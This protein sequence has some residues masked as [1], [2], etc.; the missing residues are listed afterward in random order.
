MARPITKLIAEPLAEGI[1]GKASKAA[2]DTY[3]SVLR[4]DTS[5]QAEAMYNRLIGLAVKADELDNN[6][7][8]G[9]VE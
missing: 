1:H 8:E 5:D 2:L 7:E 9:K 3:L 4:T 6:K